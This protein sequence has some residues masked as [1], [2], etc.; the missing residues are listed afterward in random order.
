MTAVELE[1]VSLTS[2]QLHCIQHARTYIPVFLKSTF[3]D[4][5][6]GSKRNR[7]TKKHPVKHRIKWQNLIRNLALLL[8]LSINWIPLREFWVDLETWYERMGSA[9]SIGRYFFSLQ[10]ISRYQTKRFVKKLGKENECFHSL[11][12][13]PSKK[14]ASGGALNKENN[15]RF[16]KWITFGP[17]SDHFFVKKYHE[18]QS[19]PSCE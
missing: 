7:L 16:S 10:C 1:I 12:R 18:S 17:K 6:Y 3:H 15:G 11:D 5:S 9:L 14:S 4:V 8:A 13:G 19:V 2:S